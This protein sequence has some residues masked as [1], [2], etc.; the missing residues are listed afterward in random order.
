MRS[1][2]AV[3]AQVRKTGLTLIELMLVLALIG[4]LAAIAIPKYANYR[5]RINQA[6]AIQDILVLQM[7]ITSYA[8]DSGTFPASLAD[9]GNG[10]RLDPWGHV[11]VY[12]DLATS[13]GK[14]QAR[15]DHRL[16][17]INSDFDLYSM[18]QD[19]VTKTQLTQKDSLD[20]IVR[21]GDGAYVGL[22]S[23]YSP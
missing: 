11:Y 14:G 6:K 10:G 4:V 17:P 15:K 18:G 9:V 20:D 3:L 22:A 7:M 21:A 1:K 12:V 5:E 8:T 16:N 19:G 2:H 23:G 13:H